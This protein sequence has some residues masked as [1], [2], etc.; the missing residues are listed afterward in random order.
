[1]YTTKIPHPRVLR[2][3]RKPPQRQEPR[4]DPWTE[5]ESAVV[6]ALA[7]AVQLQDLRRD[8]LHRRG[9]A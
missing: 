1:M 8:R 2:F 6:E 3:H 5:I 9:D 7:C 4:P